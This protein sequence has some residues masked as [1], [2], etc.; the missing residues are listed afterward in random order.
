MAKRKDLPTCDTCGVNM[1]ANRKYTECRTCRAKCPAPTEIE[2]H[3]Y[4]SIIGQNTICTHCGVSL[5]NAFR[6]LPGEE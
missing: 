2:H 3:E 6:G 4:R 1:S 5:A